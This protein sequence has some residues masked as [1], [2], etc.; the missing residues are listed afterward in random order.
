MVAGALTLSEPLILVESK[1]YEEIIEVAVYDPDTHAYLGT[2]R[3][4]E[5]TARAKAINSAAGLKTE[6][7]DAD[8][9]VQRQ[10]KRERA[11]E[12]ANDNILEARRKLENH[13]H[14]RR[15]ITYGLLPV[16]LVIMTAG[17]IG[18]LFLSLFW[19][20]VIIG[21]SATGLSLLQIG[22]WFAEKTREDFEEKVK[23]AEN[24]HRDMVNMPI[25]YYDKWPLE[26]W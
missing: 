22:T 11:T 8:L 26:Q 14:A 7:S 13:I 23:S 3:I 12:H 10:L 4:R 5:G 16:G 6:K 20:A 17:L 9:R 25:D 15:I 18:I 19:A 2:N 1:V 21:G 24:K